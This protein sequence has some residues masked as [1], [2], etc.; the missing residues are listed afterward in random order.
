[1]VAERLSGMVLQQNPRPLHLAQLAKENRGATADQDRNCIPRMSKKDATAIAANATNFASTTRS[2]PSKAPGRTFRVTKRI[3]DAGSQAT[4]ENRGPAR[5]CPMAW[6][7]FCP[8]APHTTVFQSRK[9]VVVPSYDAQ[10]NSHAYQPMS[11][12]CLEQ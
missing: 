8:S 9:N 2:G 6:P 5:I 4:R 3:P 7:Q 12:G 1:M 11:D 10:D